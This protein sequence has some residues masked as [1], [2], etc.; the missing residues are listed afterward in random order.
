MS[1]VPSISTKKQAELL[2]R[3]DISKISLRN[4]EKSGATHA[5]P[6]ILKGYSI[7]RICSVNERFFKSRISHTERINC[8]RINISRYPP[9]CIVGN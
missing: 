6:P 5:A 4:G 8:K 1:E 7:A 2:Q 3:S 9:I